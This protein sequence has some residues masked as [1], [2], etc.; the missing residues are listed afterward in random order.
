M[1][2]P[3]DT[4]ARMSHL[5]PAFGEDRIDEAFASFRLD[6]GKVLACN[7]QFLAIEE[8]EPFEGVFYIRNDPVLVEQCK[9]EAVYSSVIEFTPVPSL[10]Y[11]TAITTMGW[12]CAE[13]IGVWPTAP[14]DY[15]L[16][17]ERI[18]AP[19]MEPLAATTGP[20]MLDTQLLGQLAMTSPSGRLVLE[21][22]T[23]PMNR[24]TAVRDIDSAHWVGFFRPH[25]TDGKTHAA[26]TVPGWC[27]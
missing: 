12:K 26:A 24:P 27:K 10:Q 17:R 7:R 4:I 13:N 11:T 6:N 9:T 1:K 22:Y 23:D 18:L 25:I 19:A 15:D 2:I 3:C 5:L 20:M 8:V 16:W 21:K 14:S